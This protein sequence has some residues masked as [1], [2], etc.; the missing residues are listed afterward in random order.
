MFI[1]F[2]IRI[3]DIPAK[4]IANSDINNMSIFKDITG[5]RFG[6]LVAISP[7]KKD[8]VGKFYWICK[9]D[10]GIIKTIDGGNLRNGQKS[11]GCLSKELLSKRKKTH[12]LSKTVFYKVWRGIKDRTEDKNNKD[13]YKYGGLGIKNEWGSFEEFRDDMYES[14]LESKKILKQTTLD[15]IDVDG[16]YSKENT[17]WATQEQQGNNRRNNHS[18]TFKGVTKNIKEWAKELNTDHQALGYRLKNGWS[19]EE[20]LTTPFNHGNNIHKIRDSV[21]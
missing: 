1:S 18:I 16:N 8:G 14:Y 15:R 19:I 7:V 20:A 3:G 12:G 9:C 17:R 2:A 5:K 4:R 21:V 11:C 10:C 13:Y 6:R